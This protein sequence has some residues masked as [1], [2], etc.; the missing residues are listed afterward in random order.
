VK[1]DGINGDKKV[2]KIRFNKP[3]DLSRLCLVAGSLPSWHTFKNTFILDRSNLKAF[4]AHHRQEGFDGKFVFF[5]GK[6]VLHEGDEVRHRQLRQAIVAETRDGERPI[7]A[8]LTFSAKGNEAG[9]TLYGSSGQYGAPDRRQ[10]DR[11]AK[12]LA[13]E[14]IYLNLTSQRLFNPPETDPGCLLSFRLDKIVD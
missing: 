5:Q 13:T 2:M 4:I 11:V 3:P 14:L 7:A 10:F 1:P 12:Y 6:L 9:I 8:Y